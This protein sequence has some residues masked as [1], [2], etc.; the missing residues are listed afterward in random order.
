VLLDDYAYVGSEDQYA[1]MNEFA[2]SHGVM[3]L[4]MPSGQGLLIK[5]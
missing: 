1:A 5:P 4:T 2:H 3:I